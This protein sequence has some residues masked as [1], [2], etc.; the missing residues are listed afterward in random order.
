M[1]FH[2]TD[3]T[4]LLGQ[5]NKTRVSCCSETIRHICPKSVKPSIVDLF[6][7]N[8]DISVLAYTQLCE[9]YDIS[10]QTHFGKID[11]SVIKRRNITRLP[12]KGVN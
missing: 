8:Y 1:R 3:N 10:V 12:Q 6:P 11:T 2:K 4:Y 7:T 9:F 5:S